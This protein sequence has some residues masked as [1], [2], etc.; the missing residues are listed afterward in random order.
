[1]EIILNSWRGGTKKQYTTYISQW[2]QH[3]RKNNVDQ[4]KPSLAQIL[5]F[6][7]KLSSTLGY[8]AVTTARS[9]LSSFIQLDGLKIGDHPIVT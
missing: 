7:A 3:C 5:G 2:A 6:L 4:I 9:A 1:M 8:S